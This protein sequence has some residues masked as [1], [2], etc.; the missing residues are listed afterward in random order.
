MVQ[1]RN[2]VLALFGLA[3]VLTYGAYNLMPKA[4][5]YGCASAQGVSLE[6]TEQVLEAVHCDQKS[7][8]PLRPATP[9]LTLL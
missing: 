4:I 9:F 5:F 2:I 1:H 7:G 6:Y 8:S 3:L